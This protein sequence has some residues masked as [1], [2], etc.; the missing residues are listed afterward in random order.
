MYRL[1]P[2]FFLACCLPLLAQEAD[3][4]QLSAST[5]LG[6]ADVLATIQNAQTV[7]AQR[8]DSVAPKTDTGETSMPTLK[9]LGEPFPVP[10]EEGAALK[11]AFADGKTYLSPSKSC[12]FR[13]NV[14]YTFATSTDK[15]EF[16][17]CFGCGEL[18]VWRADKLVSFG[19]FD[20]GYANILEI[21]QRLFPKDEF[22]AKFTPA[23]FK[24]R[25]A[26]MQVPH[27]STSP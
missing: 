19:P 6:G 24:E 16:V 12:Q 9:I 21:T 2:L 11:Q 27:P 17:L 13:A 3:L 22:I 15:I 7:T 20:G 1:F 26:L 18:E 10:A 25:S 23:S 8:V 14:R 5:A 4:N